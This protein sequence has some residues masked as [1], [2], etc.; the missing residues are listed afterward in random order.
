MNGGDSATMASICEQLVDQ[1]DVEQ[2]IR[3]GDVFAQLI[4]H[5]MKQGQGQK[6]YEYLERMKKKKIVVTP[7]LDANVI[8]N[9][10]KAMGM[11]VP[12]TGGQSKGYDDGINEDIMDDTGDF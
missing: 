6:A 7:Y 3:L 2:A 1:K 5:Y 11:S 8:E 12:E 9:I 4:E 10:Y